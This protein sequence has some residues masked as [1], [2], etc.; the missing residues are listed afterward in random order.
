MMGR[1]LV[2]EIIMIA[3]NGLASKAASKAG[4]SPEESA[5]MSQ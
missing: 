3:S 1:R 5:P 4:E 2:G